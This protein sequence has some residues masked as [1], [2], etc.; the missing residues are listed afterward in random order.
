MITII[1]PILQMWKLR[2][3]GAKQLIRLYTIAQVAELGF[4]LRQ[5]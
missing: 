1:T 3:G 5:I 4:E 2:L